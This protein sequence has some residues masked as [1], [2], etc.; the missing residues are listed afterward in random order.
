M[1]VY[2]TAA[3]QCT[4]TSKHLCGLLVALWLERQMHGNPGQGTTSWYAAMSRCCHAAVSADDVSLCSR[5]RFGLA[6]I[7]HRSVHL[8]SPR[9]ICVH[10]RTGFWICCTIPAQLRVLCILRNV[11]QMQ[12]ASPGWKMLHGASGELSAGG[13]YVTMVSPDGKD[14]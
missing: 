14:L 11:Q 7:R 13:S 9:E 8:F 4:C 2:T 3:W 6:H 12:F 1:C 5:Q 10:K